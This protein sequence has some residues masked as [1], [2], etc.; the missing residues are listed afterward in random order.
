VAA[1]TFTVNVGAFLL[2]CDTGEVEGRL[3]GIRTEE[4]AGK[5]QRHALR[6]LELAAHA[7]RRPQDDVGLDADL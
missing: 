3:G 4:L 6:R 2:G 7:V 5:T 1:L